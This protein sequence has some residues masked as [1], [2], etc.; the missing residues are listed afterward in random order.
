IEFDDVMNQQRNAIYGMRRRA[1]EGQG[2]EKT[3]L[4]MISDV[5]SEFLDAYVPQGAK[6]ADWNLDAFNNVLNQYFNFTLDTAKFNSMGDSEIET[7]VQKRIR[8]NFEHQKK[9][10]G[11]FFEQ[12]QKMILLQVIDQKWKEHLYII[13]KL[14][15]GINLR[16]YAQKDPL[17][18]Y[19]KEAFK[20]FENLNSQIAK[21]MVEKIMRVQLVLEGPQA[22]EQLRQSLGQDESGLEDLNYSAPSDQQME[23]GMGQGSSGNKPQAP[24][25]RAT[26]TSRSMDD[27]KLNRADRRRNEKKGRR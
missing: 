27:Q 19:K 11:Q 8:E 21:E 9:S 15:E 13:D 4:D 25:N 5:I 1:L 18:E 26:M 10:M 3:I 22:E 7:E 20:A 12:V 24:R 2:V 17:I 16:G 14:K 23:L 6:K